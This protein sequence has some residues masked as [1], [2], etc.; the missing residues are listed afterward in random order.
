MPLAG[1]REFCEIDPAK[2][3]DDCGDCDRCELDAKKICDNCCKCIGMDEDFL[4]AII[5]KPEETD[6][7]EPDAP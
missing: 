1:K 5:I 2:R 4:T 7:D 3:C 6:A